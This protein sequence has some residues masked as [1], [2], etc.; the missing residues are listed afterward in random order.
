MT[1][2]IRTIFIM[3]SLI[4]ITAGVYLYQAFYKKPVVTETLEDPYLYIPTGAS[5]QEVKNILKD[6]GLMPN[7]MTFDKTAD[8]MNYIKDPMRSGRFKIEK[9][10][11]LVDL[12]RHLRSGQQAPV[13][14]VMTNERLVEEVAG[15]VARYIEPDSTE[16]LNLFFDPQF[17]EEIGYTRETLMS[18][19]IPNTYEVYWD[20]SPRQFIER[21]I[22]E[23]K[24]FWN[25]DNRLK[26]AKK[27]NM[28][29]EEVYTLASIV[30]KETLRNEEKKR[31]AGVY[32]N[33]IKKG[34]RLQADPTAVFATR[35]FGTP[36][37]T[38]FHTKY[39]SP[40]NTYMY[41]GL[42]PGPITMTSISSID[43]VLN[44]EQHDYLYFCAV[45][46][47][48]G[49]HNFARTLTQH[50]RNAEIYRQN[51]RKRGL[52]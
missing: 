27:L 17:L 39:D 24:L 20:S 38:N 4:L 35:D 50:N 34:M 8:Y 49:L 41:A 13:N 9:G 46:D 23:H 37:V 52:R 43:A 29:P 31:M 42:P 33:R 22:R 12:L 5:Y 21:M 11:T 44:A 7:E 3:G 18:L 2:L 14:V 1:R 48:S 26:K 51:L 32:L 6:K 30:E 47:G 15:K 36:R 10:W 28:T 25:R 19:F 40:Y 16:L 45:G